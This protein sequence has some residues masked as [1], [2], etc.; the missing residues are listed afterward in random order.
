MKAALIYDE[1][2]PG[3]PASW[4]EAE[5]ESPETIEALLA[6]IEAHCGEAVPVRFGPALA[7]ELERLE[8]E[9][10]FNIAEGREGPSRESI[11]AIILDHLG[12]PYTGSDGVA[13]GISLNKAL[14]KHLAR[15]I[16]I[17]TPRFGVFESGRQAA[18][19]V[20]GLRFPLL[21]K[22]NFGGS[23]VGVG[24]E[25]I[26]WE[27]DQLERLVGEY[28]DHYGQPCLVEEY[29][30][31]V[32]VTVGLLGNGQVEVLPPAR[33][34]TADGMYSA[35]DKERHE[36]EIIC[37]CRLPG[38]LAGKLA[39]WSLKIYDLIGARDFARVDYL[40]DDEGRAHFLEI[41][42]LP[43]LSPYYGVFPVLAAPAGYDHAELIGRII[44]LALERSRTARS[45]TDERLA[46]AAAQQCHHC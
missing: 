9:L 44:D 31:G 6:A 38:G 28:V 41:N 25:G 22:P 2:T 24:P 1:L 18:A 20:D 3:G 40:L 27:P 45:S 14:T 11:A 36:R 21:L 15:G 39:E 23:S 46:G 34:V 8:P 4:V 17:R 30:H 35:R 42:P 7:D 43:G 5:Y 33:I 29:V 32:D 16:G 19:R 37:P 12:I 26:A 10:A 13:L